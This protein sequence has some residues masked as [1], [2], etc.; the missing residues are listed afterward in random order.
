RRSVERYK[1]WFPVRITAEATSGSALARNVSETGMLVATRRK[2][3]VGDPVEVAL[4]L[5]ESKGSP[6]LRGTIVRSGPNEEDPSGLWPFKVA[7]TFEA[8]DPK[9]VPL[10]T[11]A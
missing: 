10:V 2:F 7:I 1:A 6:A 4:L 8:P 9:L 5:E 11:D 3:A